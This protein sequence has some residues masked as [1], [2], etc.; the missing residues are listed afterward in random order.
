MKRFRVFT[1][2]IGQ[3]SIEVLA[4]MIDIDVNIGCIRFVRYDEE[5]CRHITA[6]TPAASTVVEITEE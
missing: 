3:T 6:I 1:D 4:D 5:K 2:G